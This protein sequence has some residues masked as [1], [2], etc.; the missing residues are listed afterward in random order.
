M[1]IEN[2]VRPA[3]APGVQ[4]VATPTNRR[5][6]MNWQPVVL[7]FGIGGGITQVSGSQ[8]AQFTAYQIQRP[9]EK[10]DV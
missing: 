4:P 6:V 10:T 7:K 5:T 8:S 9:K 1:T 3:N 2:I